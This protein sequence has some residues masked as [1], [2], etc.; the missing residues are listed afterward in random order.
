MPYSDGTEVFN[1]NTTAL[2]EESIQPGEEVTK[3]S[4]SGLLIAGLQA[5]LISLTLTHTPG[6]KATTADENIETCL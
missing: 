1:R 5:N 6:P 4:K 2:T 3:D